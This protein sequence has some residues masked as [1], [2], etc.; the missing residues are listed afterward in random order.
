MVL[1]IDVKKFI[2]ITFFAFLT[3]FKNFS[4]RFL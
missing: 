1:N 2:L 4:Q 3:F